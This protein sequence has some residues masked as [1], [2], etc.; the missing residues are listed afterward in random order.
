MR[1]VEE[2]TVA[3]AFV[4]TVVLKAP[5]F[6]R[7]LSTP[8]TVSRIHSLPIFGLAVAVSFIS[9]KPLPRYS[10]VLSS[11]TS[12]IDDRQPSPAPPVRFSAIGHSRLRSWGSG[13]KTSAPR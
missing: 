8:S 9:A 1:C 5:G 3:R 6:T 2:Q 7:F 12:V 13:T 10:S 4:D 11:R